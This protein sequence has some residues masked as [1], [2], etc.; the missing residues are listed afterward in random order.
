MKFWSFSA[1]LI[2]GFGVGLYVDNP[3][4]GILFGLGIGLLSVVFLSM[5]EN[6]KS[7]STGA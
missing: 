5:V 4:P 6:R 1:F 3:F 7:N 2:L